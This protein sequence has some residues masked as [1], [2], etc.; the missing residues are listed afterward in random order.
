MF[1]FSIFIL[2]MARIKQIAVKVPKRQGAL[3]M[4]EPNTTTAMEASNIL[5]SSDTAPRLP[6]KWLFKIFFL[7]TLCFWQGGASF[8]L[9]Q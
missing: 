4:K 9:M 7:S 3:A 2:E 1:Y 8:A 6:G 5:P